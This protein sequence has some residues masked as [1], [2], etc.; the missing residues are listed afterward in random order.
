MI[1]RVSS[2]GLNLNNQLIIKSMINSV[3]YNALTQGDYLN[4][5]NQL[6][7]KL[8]INFFFYN[9]LTHWDHLVAATVRSLT[10]YYAKE[11]HP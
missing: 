7:I 5:N 2:P 6:I 1:F 11:E 8:K 4:S 3:F 9:T 10:R